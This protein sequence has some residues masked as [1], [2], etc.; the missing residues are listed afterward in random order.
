MVTRKV[1][2]IKQI[3]SW[4]FSRY[5]DYKLCPLKARLKHVDKHKEPQ[6]DAMARGQAIHKLAEDYT[7]GSIARLPTPATSTCSVVSDK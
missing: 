4:S 7:K 3:T 1:I 5:S 6:N 2:P